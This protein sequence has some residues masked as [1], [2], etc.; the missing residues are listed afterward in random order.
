VIFPG[1]MIPVLIGNNK[2]LCNAMDKALHQEG[3][4]MA[5]KMRLIKTHPK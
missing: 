2:R 4:F 1:L 3:C 5:A